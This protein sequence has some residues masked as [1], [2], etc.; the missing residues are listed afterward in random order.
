MHARTNIPYVVSVCGS[1]H[2]NTIVD[3]KHLN[4]H[5]FVFKAGCVCACACKES[6]AK[7]DDFHSNEKKKSSKS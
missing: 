3:K 2:K 4:N 7:T 6:I 1:S 5:S